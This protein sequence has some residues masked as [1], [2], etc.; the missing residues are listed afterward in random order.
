MQKQKQHYCNI[1]QAKSVFLIWGE[2]RNHKSNQ[3]VFSNQ[4]SCC[5]LQINSNQITYPTKSLNFDL[6]QIFKSSNI[7]IT[8][9]LNTTLNIELTIGIFG[10][11]FAFFEIMLYFIFFYKT[12]E[13]RIHAVTEQVN[14]HLIV[15]NVY[16]KSKKWLVSKA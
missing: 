5:H 1:L 12:N 4:I 8:L 13:L 11:R 9:D 7:W 16:T 3:Q 6:F 2:K 15:F 10:S 14:K